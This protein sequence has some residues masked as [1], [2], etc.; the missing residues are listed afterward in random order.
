MYEVFDQVD[1][2]GQPESW[3]TVQHNQSIYFKAC[4]YVYTRVSFDD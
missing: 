1:W 3:Q 2:N 4:M